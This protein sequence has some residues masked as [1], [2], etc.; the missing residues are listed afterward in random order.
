M[1]CVEA[2]DDDAVVEGGQQG[3]GTCHVNW[4]NAV[5]HPTG[6]IPPLLHHS[7]TPPATTQAVVSRGQQGST[8]VSRHTGRAQQRTGRR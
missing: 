8:G 1:A 7:D 4:A 2:K 6:C 5:L 3:G